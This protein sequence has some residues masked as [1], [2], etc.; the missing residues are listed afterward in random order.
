MA[1]SPAPSTGLYS[2]CLDSYHL[3]EPLT[4]CTFTAVV[5]RLIA[6][7]SC[8]SGAMRAGTVCQAQKVFCCMT[9]LGTEETAGQRHGDNRLTDTRLLGRGVSR[10]G[11][12]H[13]KAVT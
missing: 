10:A 4:V 3:L 1:H 13:Q 6:L 11:Y 12:L 7:T 2:T 9:A 5:I 8:E